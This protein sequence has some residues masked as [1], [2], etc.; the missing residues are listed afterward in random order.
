MAATQLSEHRLG[1]AL[2]HLRVADRVIRKGR[3]RSY[4]YEAA[5]VTTHAVAQPQ[6]PAACRIVIARGVVYETVWNG[7]RTDASLIGDRVQRYA[8]L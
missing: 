8:S 3:K 5:P 2:R 4:W 6:A 1:R 7:A